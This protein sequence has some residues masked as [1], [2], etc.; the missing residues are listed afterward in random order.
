[1]KINTIYKK[2]KEVFLKNT[3]IVDQMKEQNVLINDIIFIRDGIVIISN[4]T[5]VSFNNSNYPTEFVF[6]L[7]EQFKKNKLFVEPYD[8]GS[9]HVTED[10]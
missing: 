1:M 4:E 9:F 6:G 5:G 10:F 7:E 2:T 8:G 3:H